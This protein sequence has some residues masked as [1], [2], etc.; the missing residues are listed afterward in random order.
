MNGETSKNDGAGVTPPLSN[1]PS[2]VLCVDAAEARLMRRM[3]HTCITSVKM[4]RILCSIL[5]SGREGAE[6]EAVDAV[7]RL[8]GVSSADNPV[9]WSMWAHFARFAPA[10]CAAFEALPII[11]TPLRDPVDVINMGKVRPW[12][13]TGTTILVALDTVELVRV[14]DTYAGSPIYRHRGRMDE[15]F[16]PQPGKVCLITE[17]ELRLLR[18]VGE[19]NT[20][21][22]TYDINPDDSTERGVTPWPASLRALCGERPSLA[23]GIATWLAAG[24]YGTPFFLG[25][26]RGPV[27]VRTLKSDPLD[28]AGALALAVETNRKA[29]KI[30]RTEMVWEGG[31][32]L[33]KLVRYGGL[34]IYTGLNKRRKV[35]LRSL[36]LAKAGE[37]AGAAIYGLTANHNTLWAWAATRTFAKKSQSQRDRDLR[38]VRSSKA[39]PESTR[40]YIRY[41]Y[42]PPGGLRVRRN[43]AVKTRNLMVAEGVEGGGVTTVPLKTSREGGT[44]HLNCRA[45]EQGA[46]IVM[47]T[48][49]C[50]IR[51]PRF[52]PDN[53]TAMLEWLSRQECVVMAGL[54]PSGKVF[55]VV[56]VANGTEDQQRAAVQCWSEEAG[57]AFPATSGRVCSWLPNSVLAG[58]AVTIGAIHHT[59]WRALSL[60]TACFE[61]YQTVGDY[62]KPLK[63]ERRGTATPLERAR[64]YVET[65][66][67]A[68]EG[69]RNQNLH[70]AAWNIGDKIG[71][72]ALVQVAP[73]LLARSTLPDKE[74]RT[75]INRAI[76]R[77]ERKQN[78]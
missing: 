47:D 63:L 51:S 9:K 11:P 29:E 39:H 55:A 45:K 34:T 69:T 31:D 30:T 68:D 7:A 20:I 36:G 70:G 62:S 64:A 26:T 59:N 38:R 73:L 61:R 2:L 3:G 65:V 33:R 54:E 16:T 15:P 77:T 71:L 58:T 52:I 14:A 1:T 41:K 22:F 13:C 10:L 72:E 25:L 8:G 24:R 4:R 27:S 75:I 32:D 35:Q 6:Q 48:K 12:E 78:T 50:K 43:E 19:D 66:P 76:T 37:L 42:N 60:E 44:Y 67:L 5:S 57:R 21:V 46:E 74:K 28:D 17:G 53:P 49:R 18:L 40:G 56:K 23:V